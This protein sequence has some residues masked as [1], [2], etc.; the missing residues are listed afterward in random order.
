[1]K[2][3]VTLFLLASATSTF[4]AAETVTRLDDPA[5][6]LPAALS[7]QVDVRFS[8]AFAKN[9][10]T[11]TDFDG[12][13]MSE[14]PGGQVCLFGRNQGL[15]PEDPKLKDVARADQGDI[16]APLAD[17]SVRVKAQVVA[18]APPVPFY[19]TDKV[20]CTWNWLTGKGIGLWA[21]DCAFDTG[22]WTV[23]YDEAADQ[24][25]LSVDK[26]DPYPVLRQF[27]VETGQGPDALLPALKAKGLVLD[28][29][30][31][32][33]APSTEQILPKGWA[34]WQVVPVGKLK[35]DF[36]ALP[37][38][39]IPDPPCGDLGMTVDSIGFFMISADHPERILYVDLGQ[40]GTMFDP[41]SI[42]LF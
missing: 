21:E 22:H 28:N 1:M 6:F 41:Y 38:D 37:R 29:A 19:S 31:C 4:A 10:L 3:I 2:R 32:Q 7:K 39:E 8:E 30:E 24:F 34:A 15:D 16:C 17:V 23:A 27:R 12:V 20:K 13:V 33:F 5:L 35:K 36:D 18:D 42:R 9:R 25:T 11:K 40:D 14:L 26:G